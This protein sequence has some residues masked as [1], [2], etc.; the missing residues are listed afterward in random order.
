MIAERAGIMAGFLRGQIDR[1]TYARLL[2]NLHVVYDALEGAIARYADSPFVTPFA[3]PGLSRRNALAAD[4]E[5]FAGAA[6]SHL[7][8]EAA[9]HTLVARLHETTSPEVVCAH[10]YVRYMGD[11][12]GGQALRGVV[13]RIFGLADDR[14]VDFYTFP[15]FAEPAAV[16]Q[17]IRASLDALPVT[18]GGDAMVAEAIAS[19]AAHE[20][21]FV[22]LAVP[23]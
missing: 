3:H 13:R 17:E 14:G 21:L 2:R 9:A 16:K 12:S 23:V 5:V 6:W 7:P 15:A 10:A 1:Q 19:F 18:D 20:Q 4:A 8:V 11:L 22:Q